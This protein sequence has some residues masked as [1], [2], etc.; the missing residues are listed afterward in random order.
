MNKESKLNL[1]KSDYAISHCESSKNYTDLEKAPEKIYLQKNTTTDCYEEF[2]PEWFES[3][4]RKSDIEYIRT[5]VIIEKVCEFID[6]NI[7]GYIDITHK[8]GDEDVT[9]QREF[10]NYF[11]EEF[12]KMKDF[13]PK[14]EP[15]FKVGNWIVNKFHDIC[16]ITDIDLEDGYYICESNRFG[17]TDGDIDLTDKSFH[18]W[19]IKDAKDG[20]VLASNDGVDILIF[21][22]FD[23]NTNFSSYYNIE[24]RGEVGW[25]NKSFI[26]ATKEQSNLLFQKMHE[27]GYMWD[28][29][30]K[31]IL[32]LK[33]E[34]TGE[35][36]GNE[37]KISPKWTE[38]DE[39]VLQGIWDEILA[40]KHEAKEYDWKTYDKYLDWLKSIKQRIEEQ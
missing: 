11:K 1:N 4:A 33:A 13:T 30:S 5:D 14:L 17:D 27:A 22:N 12:I 10:I 39:S 20:D 32:S 6:Q 9:L 7:T 18:L 21:R 8:G 25:S 26:P 36:R 24:E 29:E 3:R 40:N 31:Q 15:K 34:S 19:D 35:V 37:G 2:Y 16:L 23:T 38:E 28:A